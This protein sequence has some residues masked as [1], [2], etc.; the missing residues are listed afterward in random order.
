MRTEKVQSKDTV[1]ERGMRCSPEGSVFRADTERK[2]GSLEMTT[3]GT[4]NT[5]F[6]DASVSLEM[7]LL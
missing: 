1:W 5:D 4:P 2:R 3:L 7:A 6:A